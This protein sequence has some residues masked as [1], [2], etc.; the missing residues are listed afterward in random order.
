MVKYV[1]YGINR[2]A[3]DFLYIF[4]NINV[5]CIADDCLTVDEFSGYKVKKIDDLLTE[6]RKFEKIIICD[7]EK[8][9]KRKKLEAFGLQYGKEFIY[10][11]D[12]FET[13]D[14]PPIPSSRKIAVWGTGNMSGLLM[15]ENIIKPN[16]FVDTYKNKEKY[17]DVSVYRP[18]EIDIADYF[19]IV[20]VARANEIYTFLDEKGFKR[21]EDY[22]SYQDILGQPSRLLRKTIFSQEYYDLEC[23][24]MLN[25]LE[26]LNNGATRCCCTTFV[27][28]DLDNIMS[29]DSGKVWGSNLHKV[30]CLSIENRTYSFCDKDMCPLFVGKS[31][32]YNNLERVK[33]ID[34]KK[35]EEHPK[36][37]AVG[38]DPSCNLACSTCRQKTY[39]AKGIEKEKIS[40]ITDKLISDYLPYVDFLI[41]AGDGEVFASSAYKAIYASK[42]C[43]PRYIR[44]LTNG[45]L[46]TESNWRQFKDKKASKI[47]MTVSID[48]ATAKTYEQ[49]RCNGNFEKLKKNMEFASRLRKDGE[50]AYL[51]FNFVVQ[52]K[53]YKEMIEFTKWGEELGV[54]EIFFTKILNWGTY[55]KEE[56]KEVSMMEEDGVTPKPEL[57]AILNHPIVRN[58]KIVDLGTIRYTHK[59]DYI[60][61][62]NNYYMWEL[63]KR[64]GRLFR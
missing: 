63:E 13:L 14:A 4:D 49:I 29:G 18:D 35:M 38:Y 41:L 19:F 23:H 46:F 21:G 56:F 20:A 12:M 10:E 54:D 58:S 61:V 40:L 22:C 7:F 8:G 34:Y 47:M 15:K 53:N 16:I 26:V 9:Y 31:S 30:M 42:E 3:K 45:T 44:L 39:F 50:L 28:Q 25:H 51:R 27:A 60:D 57:E 5:I 59:I 11:E 48:A 17:F 24:T 37:V 43:N 33:N 32:Q 52:Q 36:V 55:S 1:I 6:E 62:V 2:V 64:G